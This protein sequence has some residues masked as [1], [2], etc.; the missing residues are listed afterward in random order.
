MTKWKCELCNKEFPYKSGLVRHQN[1]K[2]P[3][4]HKVISYKCGDCDRVFSSRQAKWRHK[5]PC[6]LNTQYKIEKEQRILEKEQRILEQQKHLLEKERWEL[7][8]KEMEIQI[9]SLKNN[10]EKL[11]DNMLHKMGPSTITQNN[12]T[13]N[14][15]TYI[16]QVNNF[17]QENKD[18]IS[19]KFMTN[20][21]KN[22]STA[23]PELLK[24]IHFHPEHPENRNVKITNRK[25]RFAHVF[26]NEQWQIANKQDVLKKMVDS[27]FDLLDNCYESG[28]RKEIDK[29]KQ[30]KYEKFQE[31]MDNQESTERQKIRD[32]TEILVLNN[33]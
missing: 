5:C 12:N 2:T 17:G 14:N 21:L 6:Q 30:H 29:T 22:P 27:G 4:T 18:Y 24:Q 1:R 16:V 31:K 7:D 25:E 32:D 8:R 20:L 33:S 10:M 23:V 13:Q 28:K 3:C 9:N 11:M 19:D 15:N 26:K